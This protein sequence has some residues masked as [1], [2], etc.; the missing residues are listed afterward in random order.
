MGEESPPC[1]RKRGLADGSNPGKPVGLNR[2]AL[3]TGGW[4]FYYFPAALPNPNHLKTMTF[5]RCNTA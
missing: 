1:D 5:F 2:F 4:N 3:G